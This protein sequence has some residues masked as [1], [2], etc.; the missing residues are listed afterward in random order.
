MSSTVGQTKSYPREDDLEKHIHRIAQ[1]TRNK[2]RTVNYD[3]SFISCGERAHSTVTKYLVVE[4]CNAATLAYDLL[5]QAQA[6]D[7]IF[8]S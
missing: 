7:S 4:R 5:S 1:A 2:R 8:G 6:I 3:V